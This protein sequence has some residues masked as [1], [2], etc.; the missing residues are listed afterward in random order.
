MYV[1]PFLLVS[2][3]GGRPFLAMHFMIPSIILVLSLERVVP[4]E[5]LLLS[6]L[7]LGPGGSFRERVLAWDL[8]CHSW[9]CVVAIGIDTKL[10][11]LQVSSL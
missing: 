9:L 3:V 8:I 4:L 2:L 11:V 5:L 1:L 7:S 6:P 10:Q